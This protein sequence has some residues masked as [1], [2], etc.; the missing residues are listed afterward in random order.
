MK[1]LLLL[2]YIGVP[3]PL[4]AAS[5]APVDIPTMLA[6]YGIAAPFVGLCWW[7]M[8]RAQKQLDEARSE[9]KALQEQAISRERELIGRVAPMIYDGARLY[10]R[11]NAQL[12]QIPAKASDL[13][14]LAEQVQH[15]IDR[16]QER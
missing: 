12:A 1:T 8:Q 11:G 4:L 2:G 3:V 9:I 10:E 14:S 15:L 13:A 7:Q 5:D 16:L 6:S